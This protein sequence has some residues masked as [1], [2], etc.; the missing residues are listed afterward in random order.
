MFWNFAGVLSAL[1][2]RPPAAGVMARG[3]MVN[4]WPSKNELI[5][6]YCTG[7]A[8]SDHTGPLASAVTGKVAQA[9]PEA[10]AQGPGAACSAH[11]AMQLFFITGPVPARV[12]W[13]GTA[14]GP[15]LT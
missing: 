6:R 3:I 8:Y 15:K 12:A 4:R 14:G 9:G 7:S 2:S 5:V 1:G 11:Y 13:T 10:R